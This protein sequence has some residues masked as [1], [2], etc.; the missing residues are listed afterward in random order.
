MYCNLCS[1]MIFL[2][3]ATPS[4]QLLTFLLSSLD[5]SCRHAAPSLL[6]IHP[7]PLF[8]I[9]HPLLPSALG[10][11]LP[12]PKAL[13]CVTLNLNLKAG[14]SQFSD[15]S[16]LNLSGDT[17]YRSDKDMS[18]RTAIILNKYL[19]AIVT[20]VWS[21]ISSALIDSPDKDA[22]EVNLKYGW[23]AFIL[24]TY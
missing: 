9:P 7:A 4:W 21:Q 3:F 23:G 13:W 10:P 6:H 14:K 2:S 5:T 22:E 8:P 24:P 15:K 16:N 19:Q 17:I 20:F 12:G 18:P 11:T 1:K